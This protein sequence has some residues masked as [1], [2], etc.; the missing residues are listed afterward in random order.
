M[1]HAPCAAGQSWLLASQTHRLAPLVPW[2]SAPAERMEDRLPRH[3]TT[4]RPRCLCLTG[5]LFLKCR[6]YRAHGATEQ[7]KLEPGGMS[8]VGVGSGGPS[9]ASVSPGFAAGAAESTGD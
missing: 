6:H 2:T 1:E 4:Q 7:W 9:L 5:F 3:L 8:R